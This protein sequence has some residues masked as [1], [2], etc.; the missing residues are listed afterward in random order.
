MEGMETSSQLL[1]SKKA[2]KVEKTSP[3]M[4]MDLAKTEYD[5]S[6][7]DK[8]R[9]VSEKD[10]KGFNNVLSSVTAT[11]YRKP[12]TTAIDIDDESYKS[13]EEILQE[14]KRESVQH[15]L[16]RNASIEELHSDRFADVIDAVKQEKGEAEKTAINDRLEK[17]S[18]HRWNKTKRKKL[19]KSREIMGTAID[20][21]SELQKSDTIAKSDNLGDNEIVKDDYKNKF[22]KYN[23]IYATIYKSD[24]H[25]AEAVAK[26][27]KEETI[28]K[29]KARRTYFTNMYNMAERE[30][31]CY[32][33]E[34]IRIMEQSRRQNIAK[35]NRKEYLQFTEKI[36]KVQ[37]RINFYN[38]KADEI[39][40]K[41]ENEFVEEQKLGAAPVTMEDVAITYSHFSNEEIKEAKEDENEKKP[42]QMHEE[43][44]NNENNLSDWEDFS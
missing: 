1:D 42:N 7:H 4:N 41:M 29:V 11:G 9:I 35:P 28:I 40:R 25:L 38:A 21:I 43:I 16:G 44:R 2:E 13:D 5:L 14:L 15:F 6:W 18:S 39:R 23:E 17:K 27:E 34:N 22:N 19:K 10:R 31:N 26:N 30:K 12:E 37:E 33:E 8:N 32:M 3:F 20:K 24:C 36:A